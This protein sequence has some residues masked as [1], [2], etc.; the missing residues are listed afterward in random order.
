[1]VA[2]LFICVDCAVRTLSLCCVIKKRQARHYRVRNKGM[3][4]LLSYSQAGPGRPVK[5]EQEEISRNHVQAFIPGSV[6]LTSHFVLLPLLIFIS[7]SS[8]FSL[9]VS[10]KTLSLARM[11]LADRVTD[12]ESHAGWTSNCMAWTRT[13]ARS[14]FSPVHAVSVCLSV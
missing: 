8:S 5:Q 1:M 3:Q 6:Q 2:W 4:I 9:F 13:L 7:L 10:T 11:I 14:H 12:R